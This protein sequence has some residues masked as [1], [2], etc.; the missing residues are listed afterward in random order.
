MNLAV[1]N[2]DELRAQLSELKADGEEM[3]TVNQIV[4][5]AQDKLHEMGFSKE[6]STYL[7][8]R[9]GFSQ[10]QMEYNLKEVAKVTTKLQAAEEPATVPFP[11]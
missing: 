10:E 1:T 6:K 8:A 4:R 5:E 9:G 3:Q 2:P 7:F 11:R